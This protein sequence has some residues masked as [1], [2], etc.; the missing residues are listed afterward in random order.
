ML[1]KQ[2]FDYL[3][4]SGLGTTFFNATFALINYFVDENSDYFVDENGDRFID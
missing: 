2:I 1:G 4:W 3:G